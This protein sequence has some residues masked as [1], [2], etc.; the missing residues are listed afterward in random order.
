MEIKIVCFHVEY[1]SA[2]YVTGHQVGCELDPAEVGAYEPRREFGQQ[3]LGNSGNSFNQ[4]MS[5][6]QYSCQQ[7]VYNLFLSYDNC[8]NLFFQLLYL[9]GKASQVYTLFLCLS[10]HVFILN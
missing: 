9:I 5:V 2:E 7:Q 3:R 1:G 4:Y 6:C 8:C 10:F